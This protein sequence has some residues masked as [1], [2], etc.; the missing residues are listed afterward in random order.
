MA[1]HPNV[2]ST[3]IIIINGVIQ[4]DWEAVGITNLDNSKNK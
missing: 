2:N 4:G 1:E 3:S